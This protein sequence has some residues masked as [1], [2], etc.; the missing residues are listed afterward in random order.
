MSKENVFAEGRAPHV[1]N[2]Y[3]KMLAIMD[4][5]ESLLGNSYIVRSSFISRAPTL[6]IQSIPYA[7][8]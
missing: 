7:R 4:I 5:Y 1:P 6:G 3:F 8:L 2:I